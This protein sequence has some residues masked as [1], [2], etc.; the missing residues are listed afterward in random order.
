MVLSRIFEKK[1]NGFYVDVGAHHPKRFSNTYLFY[2]KGWRGINIDAM[3]GSMREF[4]E[5]RCRDINLELGVAKE[6]GVLDY[7]VFNE[8]ALNGFSTELSEERNSAENDYHVREIIKVEVKPLREILA[9]Y[10][11]GRAI[12]FL[13]VDVEGFDLDV[14]RSNDWSAYRPQI[15]LAECLK[16]SLHNLHRDPV[17]HFMREQDYDVYSK[18]V[19][20]VFFEDLRLNT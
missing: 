6:R 17:V 2:R 4:K 8:P 11:E 18:Q 19:N 13:S 9:E 16:F 14:L 3:P 1:S 7:Y 12:D 15:V 5:W 20:T 10:L